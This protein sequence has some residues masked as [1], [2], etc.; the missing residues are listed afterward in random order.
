MFHD[1]GNII[2]YGFPTA[3]SATLLAWGYIEYYDGY[4]AAGQAAQLQ[5][6][7]RWFTDYFIKCHVKPNELYVHIGDSNTD[8]GV[9]LS[10]ETEA[11][12]VRASVECSTAVPDCLTE[13]ATLLSVFLCSTALLCA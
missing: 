8:F 1:G 13:T 9:F 5:R 7:L 6:V 4:A 11:L 12:Q 2:K 10:P 3:Y